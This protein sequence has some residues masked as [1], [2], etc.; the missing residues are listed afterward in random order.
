MAD[1]TGR[2]PNAGYITIFRIPGLAAMTVMSGLGRVGLNTISLA[3]VLSISS[4]T[5]A[6]SRHLV[7]VQPD[8][9]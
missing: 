8:N 1:D 3:L 7:E 4:K 2:L 9:G 6:Y 5:E